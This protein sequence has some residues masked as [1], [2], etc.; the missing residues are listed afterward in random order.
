MNDNYDFSK[1]KRGA[2]APST[3]RKK[4]ISIRF[5]PKILEWFKKKVENE[6]GGNYQS[7]MNKALLDHI[8]EDESLEKIFR[9]VLREELHHDSPKKGTP[10]KKVN[11]G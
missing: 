3:P 1:G 10:H 9:R 11:N 4:R 2:V 5:D 6:K 7:L 8:K